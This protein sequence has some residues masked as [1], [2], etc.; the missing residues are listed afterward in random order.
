MNALR[1]EYIVATRYTVENRMAQI[2]AG[3]VTALR[4]LL[5]NMVILRLPLMVGGSPTP[6]CTLLQGMAKWT[7]T[8]EL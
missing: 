3:F 8:W 4:M 7:S 6:A 2:E 5:L 1:K